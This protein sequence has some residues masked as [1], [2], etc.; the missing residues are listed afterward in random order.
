MADY[1]LVYDPAVL[2]GQ[3]RPALAL[4]WR[5]RCF[6]PCVPLCRAWA[7]AA[8]QFANRFH[9]NLDETVLTHVD[10]VPFDRVLW[11]TLAGEL[12]LFAAH[13][14]PDLPLPS[15]TLSCLLSL[16]RRPDRPANRAT[17]APIHQALY[18]SRDLSF[19]PAVYRPDSAGVNWPDDVVRLAATL[20]AVQ[21]A[22]WSAA[23]LAGL[24]DL[25]EADRAE[26]LD[27]ARE[28]FADLRDLYGRTAARSFC[29]VLENIF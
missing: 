6:D 25:A 5:Q 15:A 8:G 20:A 27:L 9:I 1:F 19:G 2:D 22:T 21:P 28:W 16:D 10:R 12:L 24:P 17:F 7:S 26:E 14:I 3:L 4:A 13:D 18:G 11:R 23:D 29:L